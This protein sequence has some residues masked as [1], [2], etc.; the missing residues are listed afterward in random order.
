MVVHKDSRDWMRAACILNSLLPIIVMVMADDKDARTPKQGKDARARSPQGRAWTLKEVAGKT[1]W[2]WLQLLIVPLALAVLGLLFSAQQD[3]RQQA[4]ENQRADRVRQLEE[5]RAQDLTLQAYLDQMS[6]LVLEDLG[7][8][9]VQTLARARTL[10]VLSRLDPSRK[11]EI[12]QFLLEANLVTSVG[13]SDP[14]IELNSAD[15]SGTDLSGTDLSGAN[16]SH[17]NL[18]E[19]NVSN[20]N[21]SNANLRYANLSNANLS[22]ANLSNAKLRGVNLYDANLGDAKLRNAPLGNADMYKVD[23]SGANLSNAKLRDGNLSE[24]DLIDADLSSA[25]LIEANLSHAR[26]FGSKLRDAL[27]IDADLTLADLETADLEIANLSGADLGHAYLSGA[28]LSGTELNNADVSGA[29]LSEANLHDAEGLT[30]EQLAA[31]KS[32]EGATM[33]NGTKHP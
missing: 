21:P 14:V 7:D 4:L 24:A 20:A 2:D 31:A 3:A 15:L 19:A 27:L 28:D 1:L 30:D 33:P 26:M 10:T 22:N 13:D 6:T 23:L 29:N 25:N 5:Q 9:K 8:P 16:L 17:A 11:E 32:L 18:I 12:M